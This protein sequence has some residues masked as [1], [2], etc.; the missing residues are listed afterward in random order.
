MR[1][2]FAPVPVSLVLGAWIALLPPSSLAEEAAPPPVA[3][4]ASPTSAQ[5]PA[6]KAS[7]PRTSKGKHAREKE[8]EGSEA[9]NRFQADT[10]LKSKYHLDGEPLEVDPD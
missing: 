8:I 7:K 6:R 5:P 9:R 3:D 10:V 2:R 4:P 1:R